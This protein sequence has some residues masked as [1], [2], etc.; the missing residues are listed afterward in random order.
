MPNVRCTAF[1]R[2]DDGHGWSETHD[3]DGGPEPVNLGAITS[4]FD[5]MMKLLRVPLLAGDGYYIGCRVSYRTSG[6]KIAASPFLLDLPMKGT[7]L[8]GNVPIFMSDAELAIKLRLANNAS[9][10]NSDIYLRGVWDQVIEA[11]QMNF[12]GP[13]GEAFKMLLDAYQNALCAGIYGWVGI[14]S[15]STPRGNVTGYTSNPSG[16]VQIGVLVT[17]GATMPA[18]TSIV[19]VNFA[20]INNSRSILNRAVLCQV[21]SPTTLVT[22]QPIGVTDYVSGGTFIIPSK[23]LIPYDHAAYRKVSRRKTGRPFGVGRGRRSVQTLH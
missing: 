12:G 15:T 8:L 13:I 20:R 6:G 5:S 17:N 18:N 4:Q 3:R 19:S 1:F 11:G 9:T 7:A 23:A 2:D 16:T 22:V 21:T 10:A 14:N